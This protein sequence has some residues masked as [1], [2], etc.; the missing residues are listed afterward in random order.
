MEEKIIPFWEESYK[1][2]NISA[3]GVNPNPEVKEYVELFSKY[4]KVLEA[5]CGEAKN[6][7]FLIENG[8][9]D[10]SAFDLSENA[11][12]KV[13]KIAENRGVNINA[14]VQDLCTFQWEYKY[15][16]VIS[17]GTLHF[18]NNDGWHKFLIDAKEHTNSGGLHVIQIFTNKVP[19]SDDIKEYAVGLSKE[20]E[21][22][23]IYKDWEIIDHKE[24]VL[25][26][27]HPGAPKHYHAINKVVARKR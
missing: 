12:N 10:V 25:E 3:F 15:D 5:G 17:Y 1:N 26:D 20:G 24:F 16:L 14:F 4:G 22:L 13:F 2:E 8:F 9:S 19:A 7:F 21:L 27:E 23:E 11:I 18:V 6:A